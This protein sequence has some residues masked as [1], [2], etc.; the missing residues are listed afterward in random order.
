MAGQGLQM[1]F[2][3]EDSEKILQ[4]LSLLAG[5]TTPGAGC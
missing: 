2:L 1:P 5:L 3:A 4:R